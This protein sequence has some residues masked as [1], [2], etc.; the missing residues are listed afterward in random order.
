[1]VYSFNE[2]INIYNIY[3]LS[4]LGFLEMNCADCAGMS[5]SSVHIQG[6]PLTTTRKVKCLRGLFGG[7]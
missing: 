3:I 4:L 6:I 5:R 7:S 2:R 1:M